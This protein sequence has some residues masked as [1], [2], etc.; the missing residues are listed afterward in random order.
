MAGHSKAV[1]TSEKAETVQPQTQVQRPRFFPAVWAIVWKDL[2]MERHTRQVVS[3][4]LV[5]S[6]TVVVVFNF[7]L[8]AATLSPGSTIAREAAVGFLWATI[9]L[10]GTL[11]LNRSLAAE[12]ENHSLEAVLMAPVDRSAIYLGKVISVTLFTSLVE[13]ILVPVFVI[14]FNRPF[15]RPPVLLVLFLGTIGYVAAGVLVTSMSAQTRLREVLLPVLLLPLTLPSVLAAATAASA[16]V[17]STLPGWDEVR[18]PIALVVAF[19]VLMLTAGFLTYH[20]VVE[21]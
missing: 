4:M 1:I 9:L 12:Q 2:A 7:A 18:F 8:G 21:E 14:F 11:G 13:A 19:D 3:V 15:W 5:F 6:L 16:Y 17:Q 10:A 20:Y